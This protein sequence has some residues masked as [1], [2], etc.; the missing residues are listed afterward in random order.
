MWLATPVSAQQ[1]I[2][3]GSLG[4]LEGT[5]GTDESTRTLVFVN[6]VT[7]DAEPWSLTLELPVF[8]VDGPATRFAGGRPLPPRTGSGGD[9]PG[10]GPGP[11]DPGGGGAMAAE[12]TEGEVAAAAAEETT[13]R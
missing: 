1:L 3:T 6:A 4:Y 10:P 7:L 5:Y 8:D 9:E 13:A 11:G 12:A 2:W